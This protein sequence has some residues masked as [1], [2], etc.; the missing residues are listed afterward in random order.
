M[1]CVIRICGKVKLNKEIREALNR[2][3]LRKKYSCVLLNPTKE[4]LGV[5]KFLENFVAY[6]EVKQETIEKLVEKR[7]KSVEKDK[8]IDAKK[9]AQEIEKKKPE[10]LGIKKVF[11]LHPPRGGIN[12]KLH[13]PKGVL[14]NNKEE[15]N[16]LIGRML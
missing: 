4:N 6:G 14:G 8:K 5:V 15:I 3:N 1:I 11:R 12:S 2:L 7:G 10:E 13:Y 9:I 16:K